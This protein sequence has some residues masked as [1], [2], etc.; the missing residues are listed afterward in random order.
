MY[1]GLKYKVVVQK[2]KW[3]MDRF[4]VQRGQETRH[5]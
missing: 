1:R 5:R 4:W 2:Q 3:E